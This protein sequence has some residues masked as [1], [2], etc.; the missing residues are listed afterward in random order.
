LPESSTRGCSF[1]SLSSSYCYQ[2]KE[3]SRPHNEFVVTRRPRGS[4]AHGFTL[5]ELLVVI[6][7]IGILIA[8]LLPAVQAARE[9]A[10][11]TQCTNNLKQLGIG[12][13]NF[14]DVNRQLPTASYQPLL[15]NS[16]TKSWPGNSSRWSYLT[17]LLPFV[18]QQPL[19][20]TFYN[21]NRLTDY[22]WDPNA[23]F[24]TIHVPDFMCPSDQQ[25]E[26][27]ERDNKT[28]TSY[29]GNRGDYWVDN[30]WWECRGVFGVGGRTV[31]NYGMITDGLSNTTAVAECKIGRLSK[32]VTEG[33]ATGVAGNNGKPPSLCL[34]A[35]GPGNLYRGSVSTNEWQI[36]WRWSDGYHVYS[37]YFHMLPPNSASCG[38]NA[39]SWALISASSYHPGGVNVVMLDG[40]TRFINE[41]IDSGNPAMTV[42]Q[43]SWYGGG[44]PQEFMGPSPYGVWGA[45]GTSRSADQGMTTAAQPF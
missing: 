26:Y 8:L 37:Q 17:V 41:S 30:G 34:A 15:M 43:T 14:H 19:Y 21:N 16:T 12:L 32:K 20:N 42:Q 25:R 18:E 5:V 11:R 33:F 27:T 10:R 9:A 28:P 29:H 13:Q 1:F 6:A 35:V 31:L 23:L 3:M 36:G 24:N 4:A 45:M 40:S 38:R 22:P 2:E 44:N 7:I 39:E